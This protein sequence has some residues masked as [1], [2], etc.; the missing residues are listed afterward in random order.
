M[1]EITRLDTSK[2]PFQDIVGLWKNHGRVLCRLHHS[3]G[4]WLIDNGLYLKGYEAALRYLPA[5]SCEDFKHNSYCKIN[6]KSGDFYLYDDDR[7]KWVI[8][9]EQHIV[10]DYKS[11][12][13]RFAFI[14]F[15]KEE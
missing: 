9:P 6:L 12:Y 3:Q 14:P 5:P 11:F 10:L 7:N 13:K 8:I 4:N 2:Y 15:R 1:L